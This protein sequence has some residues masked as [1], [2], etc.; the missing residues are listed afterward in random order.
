LRPNTLSIY[1]DS[2]EQ[3]L[4]HKITLTELT[5]VAFLKDP[6]QRRHHVFGLF[7]RSRNYHFEAPTQKDGQE[8][9]ELIRKLARIEEEEEEMFLADSGGIMSAMKSALRPKQG[10]AISDRTSS[11][12]TT[13][14]LSLTP[15]ALP[16]PRSSFTVEYSG[17]DFTSHSE[18]SDI[19]H[20]PDPGAAAG[21]NLVPRN[22]Q[23]VDLSD[24][25]AIQPP[26]RQGSQPVT[27]GKLTDPERV[28]WQ[29]Y[30]LYLK[31]SRGVRQ[32][33]DLWVVLRAH[34]MTLYKDA[35]EYSPRLIVPLSSIINAVEIDA[36]SR[37]K[38]HC[39]Q[40]IA[41]ERSYRFCAPSEEEL[42]RA[43][44]AFKSLL[45]RVKRAR[46]A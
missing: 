21:S 10:W 36:M 37:S 32:W 17:N 28:V 31:S 6:K 13:Q 33:R 24:D 9:V 35:L 34:S 8:W 46:T 5:A 11:P 29:G 3:Q 25:A 30:L 40:I 14:A 4:R 39:M 26:A 19:E 7:S 15:N 18:G 43:L 23:V 41:E 44:G 45:A 22:F 42:D 38:Q 2:K 12:E 20:H 1:R 16:P 27:H